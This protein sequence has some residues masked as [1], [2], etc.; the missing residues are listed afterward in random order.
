MRLK[1]FIEELQKIDKEHGENP[2]VVMADYIPV[3]APVFSNEG[4]IFITDHA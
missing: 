3:V 2:E 1:N 4:K